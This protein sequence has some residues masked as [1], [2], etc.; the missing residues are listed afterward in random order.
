MKKV[1][2]VLGTLLNQ[3]PE[4]VEAAFSNTDE[5]VAEG[6]LNNFITGNKIFTIPDYEK[7]NSNLLADFEK[8]LVVKAKSGKLSPELYGVIK[9]SVTEMNEKE[10]AKEFGI[11]SY[12]NFADLIAQA[13]AKGSDKDTAKLLTDIDELK[14]EN[15]RIA[16]ELKNSESKHSKEYSSKLVDVERESTLSKLQDELDYPVESIKNQSKYLKL[17]FNSTHEVKYEDGKFVVYKDGKPVRNAALEPI[18]VYDVM[19]QFA[20][21]N[22]FKLKSPGEGGRGSDTP[23]ASTS[24]YK[25]WSKQQIDEHVKPLLGDPE[26]AKEADEV[27]KQW[28]EQN[29]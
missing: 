18:P 16:E 12:T 1:F 20:I 13:K 28:K 29:K 3:K 24:K 11:T 8:E 21:E 7:H 26:K 14:K 19:K 9:G 15:L 10:I 2:V 27:F 6:M 4:V 23:P 5:S 22:G 17:D 25:G